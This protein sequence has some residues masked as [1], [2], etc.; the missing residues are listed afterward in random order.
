M[1]HASLFLYFHATRPLAALN[2]FIIVSK[3]P[4]CR[5]TTM[6][7]GLAIMEFEPTG[8]ALELESK[9]PPDCSILW[10]TI[11]LFVK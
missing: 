10:I 8:I 11:E 6:G 2:L 1:C 5:S 3:R 4:G 9:S 7:S